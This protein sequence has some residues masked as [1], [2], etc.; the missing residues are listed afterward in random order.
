MTS[1]ELLLELRDIQP[2]VE[3]GWW[4]LAPVWLVV[5]ATTMALFVLVWLLM[6][7]Q[8]RNRLLS[9][10]QQGLKEIRRRHV[11][12]T[13]TSQT[14]Q[15]LSAWLKQVAMA[16]YPD[17][18]VASMTGR[19]W[20]EFLNRNSEKEIFDQ[21]LKQV[22]ADEVYRSKIQCNTDL[23]LEACESWLHAISDN[24]RQRGGRRV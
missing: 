11:Q 21:E 5:I 2:P 12:Q 10:A 17:H 8:R 16:A 15:A 14:L 1:E 18:P 22:F 20:I 4:L 9:E 19:S 13:D 24:L 23:A 3:P 6:R 7:Q